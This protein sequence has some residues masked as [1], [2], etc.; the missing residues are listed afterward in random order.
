MAQAKELDI[1][2]RDRNDKLLVNWL[3]RLVSMS[4]LTGS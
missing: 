1:S 2:S 3:N 4:Q